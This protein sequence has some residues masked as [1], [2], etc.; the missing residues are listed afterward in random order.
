[1]FG[2]ELW[3]ESGTE[4]GRK[5][6]H[7]GKT[8]LEA[9]RSSADADKPARRVYRPVKVIRHLVPFHILGIVSYCVIVTLS[10]RCAV[11][12]IFDF[13]N[14]VTLKT[15]LDVHQGYWQYHHSIERIYFLLTFYSNYGS[16]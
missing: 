10:L 13:E 16:I 5:K 15:G 2:L 7:C 1:V 4:N 14:V 9:T 8:T 12:T 11:F 6:L 3:K